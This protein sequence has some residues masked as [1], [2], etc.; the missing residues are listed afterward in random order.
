MW[1]KEKVIK[2]ASK[3]SS[4]KE[5]NE[6]KALKSAASRLG[7]Y[8]EATSHIKRDSTRSKI[9]LTQKEIIAEAKQY[10]S[11]SDFHRNKPT[12]YKKLTS[13]ELESVF[14]EILYKQKYSDEYLLNQALMY[15]YP[16]EFKKAHPAAYQAILKRCLKSKAF[17]HMKRKVHS[18]YTYEQLRAEAL[19]YTTKQSFKLKS[20]SM[21][22]ASC[23]HKRFNEICSHML[24]GK[25]ATNYDKPLWLYVVKITTLDNSLPI[26]HKVGITKRSYILDRFWIDYN[27]QDTL[28]EVLFKHKYTTGKDA[29]TMEQ[30][31]INEFKEYKYEGESPL[32]R[33]KTSEMFTTDI[34]KVGL[35]FRLCDSSG[36]PLE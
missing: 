9:E 20:Y 18:K 4:M 15:E 31:I 17:S 3:I 8:K 33:T 6:N 36:E 7:I 29:Y 12:L 2:E 28:I 35:T 24:P 1:T 10:T 5:L 22:Q 30:S 25:I 34:T 23:R 13:T 14:G 26:I 11:R 27:K 16:N 21:Y 32:L 19:C